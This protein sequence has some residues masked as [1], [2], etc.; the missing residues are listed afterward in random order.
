MNKNI[1]IVGLVALVLGFLVGMVIFN[2]KTIGALGTQVQN[3]AFNFTSGF[4]AG[5]NNQFAVSSLGALTSSGAITTTGAVSTG[6]LT[7][8]NVTAVNGT[9]TTTLA[10]GSSAIST[11]VGKACLWNG[12]QYT[13]LS[14]AAGS[15]TPAYATSTTCN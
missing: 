13:I 1:H 4:N 3:E 11:K 7:T 10:I 6:A 12:T 14:F 8:K 15:V 5:L 2:H 9:A